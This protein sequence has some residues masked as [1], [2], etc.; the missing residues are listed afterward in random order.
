MNDGAIDK[1]WQVL[2][3]AFYFGLMA[4]WMGIA[5]ITYGNI[6]QTQE[7]S[8]LGK[9]GKKLLWSGFFVS[10]AL[11]FDSLYWLIDTGGRFGLIAYSPHK[12]LEHP[13]ANMA[14]KL[15]LIVAGVIFL[16]ICAAV[17]RLS[18]QQTDREY[19]SK[20]ADRA[21]DAISILDADGKVLYWNRAAEELFRW[22]FREIEGRCITEFMVP[23]ALKGQ[24]TEFLE[25][26]RRERRAMN[27]ERT[28]R[29]TADG[30]MVEV[31]IN[32]APIMDTGF[33]G[34]ISIMRAAPPRNPLRG[35]PY[36]KGAH[37]LTRQAGKVFV[38]MPYAESEGA[39]SFWQ[40][41]IMPVATRLSLSAVRADQQLGTGRVV[42][43]VF[44][45]IATSELVVADISKGNPNVMYEVGIAHTLGIDTIH[46]IQEGMQIPFSLR[47]LQ[48]IR[49]QPGDP[50][51]SQ[52]DLQ[53]AIV[54]KRAML[55]T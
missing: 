28:E 5:M 33:H 22:H 18:E 51:S 21:F 40:T 23:V 2:L 19:F 30:G 55:L 11:A 54:E 13:Y 10:S 9:E 7:P 16:R 41:L 44:E 1:V 29:L 31:S 12:Y 6:I 3:V 26:I 20:I 53:S 50:D 27:V 49:Y 15:I 37:S 34:Y 39:T 52:R 38:A 46:L 48:I 32:T 36:F 8:K 35:N 45:D 42:D 4:V 25:T 43:R 17:A 14:E 24:V 47:H